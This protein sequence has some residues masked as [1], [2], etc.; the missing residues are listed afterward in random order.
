MISSCLSSR[1]KSESAC[2]GSIA[3]DG[4][5]LAGRWSLASA[6]T[7]P[8]LLTSQ[9]TRMI[10]VKNEVQSRDLS[11]VRALVEGHRPAFRAWSMRRYSIWALMLRRS[12]SAQRRSVS[13]RAGLSRSRNRLLSAIGVHPG[14]QRSGVEHRCGGVIAA[15]H[16]HEV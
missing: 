5:E 10:F 6:L 14:V 12:S 7:K 1:V 2:R 16:D 11:W 15:E 8:S 9:P 13:K 4:V 3:A